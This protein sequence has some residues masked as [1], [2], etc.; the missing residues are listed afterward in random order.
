M[1]KVLRI[2]NENMLPNQLEVIFDD[3]DAG[4]GYFEI[5]GKN[6]ALF[7]ELASIIMEFLLS[8]YSG[9]HGNKYI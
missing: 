5:S 2:L 3:Y 8:F 7:I 1:C 6:L 4:L 9:F